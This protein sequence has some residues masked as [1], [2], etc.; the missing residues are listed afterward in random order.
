TAAGPPATE[1]GVNLGLGQE[2]VLRTEGESRLL[3]DG[4]WTS[5]K[6]RIDMPEYLAPGVYVEEVSFRQ[7]SIEGVSTS[8]A[9][10]IGPTRCGPVGDPPELLTSFSD[11]TRIYG[12][13][14]RL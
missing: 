6:G 1:L 2:A 3:V 8:V 9:G 12:G 11:F 4:R 5:L 13:I 10:F 7:K 14:D